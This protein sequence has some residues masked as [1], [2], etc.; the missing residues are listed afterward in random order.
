[1]I[2]HVDASE[3]YQSSTHLGAIRRIWWSEMSSDFSCKTK[4]ISPQ[5]VSP[6]IL[7]QSLNVQPSSYLPWMVILITPSK[8]KASLVNHEEKDSLHGQ[9]DSKFCQ[10]KETEITPWGCT[11]RMWSSRENLRRYKLWLNFPALDLGHL[12]VRKQTVS[13]H[14]QKCNID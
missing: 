6:A 5:L 4:Q 12:P 11:C 1:M 8:G 10:E 2:Q 7:F 13:C 14:G 9:P 3:H